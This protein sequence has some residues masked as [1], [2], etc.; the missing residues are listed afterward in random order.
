MDNFIDT[1]TTVAAT[2]IELA[3]EHLRGLLGLIVSVV[4][5]VG[6]HAT[7]QHVAAAQAKQKAMFDQLNKPAA[8]V[9][10]QAQPDGAAAMRAALGED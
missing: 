1:L 9:Q 3:S 4:V 6:A 5:L 8:Q 7:F 2:V 10:A